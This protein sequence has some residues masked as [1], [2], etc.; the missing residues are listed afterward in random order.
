MMIA[1]QPS[2]HNIELLEEADLLMQLKYKRNGNVLLG[3]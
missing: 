3:Y 2:L 1:M